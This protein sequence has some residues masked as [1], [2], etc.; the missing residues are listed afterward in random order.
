MKTESIQ[1][2]SKFL[3]LERSAKTFS[4]LWFIISLNMLINLQKLNKTSN[5][6]YHQIKEN[7]KLRKKLKKNEEEEIFLSRLINS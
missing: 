2:L 1:I 5:H 4:D 7:T 3:K 6:Y